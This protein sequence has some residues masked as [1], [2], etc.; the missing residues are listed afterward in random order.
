MSNSLLRN[1][2]SHLSALALAL[3]SWPVG[4]GFSRDQL[5]E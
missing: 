5:A 2:P 4:L 3:T 1:L